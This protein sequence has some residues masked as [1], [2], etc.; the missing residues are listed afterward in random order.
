MGSLFGYRGNAIVIEGE[1][2]RQHAD[3]LRHFTPGRLVAAGELLPFSFT[4]DDFTR[5]TRRR[6]AI[7]RVRRARLQAADVSTDTE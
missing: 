6:P 1:G 7:S 5:A 4:L 2:F 3:S